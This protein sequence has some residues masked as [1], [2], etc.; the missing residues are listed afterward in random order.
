MSRPYWRT[1]ISATRCDVPWA[2]RSAH[3]SAPWRKL[4]EISRWPRP[5]SSFTPFGFEGDDRPARSSLLRCAPGKKASR[6]DPDVASGQQQSRASWRRRASTRGSKLRG[7]AVEVAHDACVEGSAFV[8]GHLLELVCGDD[9]WC[10]GH[11]ATL[12]GAATVIVRP[13]GAVS[14]ALPLVVRVALRVLRRVVILGTDLGASVEWTPGRLHRA[15]DRSLQRRGARSSRPAARA[16]WGDRSRDQHGIESLAVGGDS[17]RVICAGL[18]SARPSHIRQLG[19]V[20]CGAGSAT[21]GHRPRRLPTRRAGR[22]RAER[23]HLADARRARL[24]SA[25]S[26]RARCTNRR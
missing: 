15:S 9:P 19:A 12:P 26:Q 24:R 10:G 13:G 7:E 22:L 23:T 8:G 17:A 14:P 16:R 20:R 1:A 3:T 2:P 25:P 18:V 6:P 11:E 4:C 5:E 21:T